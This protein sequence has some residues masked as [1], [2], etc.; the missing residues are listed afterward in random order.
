MKNKGIVIISSVL[1][2]AGAYFV[3]RYFFPGDKK[4]ADGVNP[5]DVAQ[6]GGSGSTESGTLRKGSKGAKVKSLQLLL[7]RIDPKSLPKFGADGD[8]GSETEAAVMKILGKT[9]VSDADIAELEKMALRVRFP[10]VAA[11]AGTSQPKPLFIA[12]LSK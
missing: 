11:P 7:L 8:F 4:K 2:L 5:A 12:D 10:Y 6:G 3:Y 1:A 9:F